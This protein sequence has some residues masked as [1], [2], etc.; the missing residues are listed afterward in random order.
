MD[1]INRWWNQRWF[2][3]ILTPLLTLIVVLGAYATDTNANVPVNDKDALVYRH[4]ND[5][6]TA[7]N[8]T[9]RWSTGNSQ[10]VLPQ[11]GTPSHAIVGMD[12]WLLKPPQPVPVQLVAN[13]IPLF[14]FIMPEGRRKVEFW[15]PDTLLGTGDLALSIKSPAWSPSNDPRPLGIA[16]ID[17]NFAG[18]GLTWPPL[19]Q[20]IVLPALALALLLLL[21]YIHI[22]LTVATVI[23]LMVGISLALEAGIRPL[24][25]APYTHRVL[26]LILLGHL[27]LILWMSIAIPRQFRWR[28]PQ[29]VEPWQLVTLL[30]ISYWMALIDQWALSLEVGPNVFPRQ[31]TLVIGSVTLG[32]LAVLALAPRLTDRIRHGATLGILALSGIAEGI[33]AATFSFHR[34]G[35]D[36][37]ILWRAAYDFHLGRPLYKVADVL[38]NHF[39]HVFKVPPFYGMLFLPFATANDMHVLLAHRILNVVILLL[40]AIILVYLLHRVLGWRLAIGAVAIVM[41]LMQAPFDTIA[42]GQIDIVLLFLLTIALIGLRRNHP[43]VTG[44]ALTLGTL[45]KLYPL[46]LVG[47]LVVK[48][49]WRTLG[50]IILWMIV[51]NAIAI[52]VMGWD[53]HVTYITQV[54]PNISGGTSW[55]EN[56]TLNGFMS[57]LL[58]GTMQTDPIKDP[59]INGLTYLGFMVIAGITLG[60]A[61]LPTDRER[62]DYALQYSSFAVVMVLAVP[63]AWM[64]YAAITILTFLVVIWRAREHKVSMAQATALAL[65]FT[66]IAYGNQWSFFTGT[67]KFG[68]PELA[69]S[70]K[71]YGLITLWVT[72]MIS[73]WHPGAWH[74]L[75]EQVRIQLNPRHVLRYRHANTL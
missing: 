31:G 6:E 5:R 65:A 42:Y 28:L 58:T 39:G 17:T 67:I 14:D 15:V 12:L 9:Y 34:S 8:I 37:F 71:F 61:A 72:L 30:G 69:L 24:A 60:L 11:V 74:E 53:T 70:Y 27:A 38:A 63:A 3:L 43:L 40:T 10:I 47:F 44:L 64:H 32:I 20:L 45:F 52:G 29:R 16:V 68:L 33:Y 55:V 13:N 26:L 18:W 36:F 50:A 48:G 59:L 46:I 22:G 51:L 54:L 21:R 66:L 1:S 7:G 56:Q 19:R 62:S 49:A 23:A 2:S 41:G 73:L 75:R 35:P 4:F 57:R 25:V